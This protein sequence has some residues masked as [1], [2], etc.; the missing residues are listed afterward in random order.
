M[1]T[2]KLMSAVT[3][4]CMTATAMLSSAALEASAAEKK[5]LTF[6]IRSGG[7]NEVK[8]SAADIAAGDFTVPV[9]IFIP[10]NPGVNGINLKLQ[11]NDGE[12]DKNGKFGN[13]GLYLSDGML[14]NP[15]C[16]DSANKGDAAA[17]V[18]RAFNFKDMNISWLFSQ[19]PDLNA[20]AAVQAETT[21]WDASAAWAYS[22][23]FAKANL[24]IP[25]NTPAGSYKLDI[26]KDK[27]LNARS[28]ELSTPAYGQSSCCGADSDTALSFDS[29]PLNVVVEAAPAAGNGWKDSYDI[30]GEKHYLILGDVC[31]EPGKTVNVPV[32]IFNDAGTAGIQLFFGMDSKLKLNEFADDPDANYAY[33]DMPAPITNTDVRP[34]SFTFA[35]EDILN[36]T[37]GG[38][39]TCLN[40]TIPSDAAEGTVYDISFTED[41]TSFLKIVDREGVKLPV[42]YY[43]G[44]IT[45]LSGNKTALNRTNVSITEIGQTT[46][47]TLFNAASDSVSWKSSDESVATVDQNGFVV[48][49]KKGSATITA[50]DNGT[51][52]TCTV[53]VGSLFGDV[54]ENGEISAADA[55]LALQNYV[56]VMAKNPPTLSEARQKIADVN[57]KDG[58]TVE[59]AQFILQYY[60]KKVVGKIASTNWREITG[61]PN[62]PADQ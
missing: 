59:D 3:A 50:T 35:N 31:G 44:S 43:N 61:N 49:K 8:I 32:M 46:N 34:S 42:N 33:I 29:V 40:I 2:K 48:T 55:Q 21:A 58:V 56:S 15:F 9:D 53:N 22:N 23:A 24:V 12:V 25:K 28:A 1:R 37:N 20:D 45:V 30:A 52:Y 4:F 60:V 10:E 62:A 41:N 38:V 26:R 17:S 19:N 14:A 47:L 16:F 11:I 51:P 27:F 6:D 36:V 57:G 13:Y 54:D 7:K 18:A 39:I 5:T